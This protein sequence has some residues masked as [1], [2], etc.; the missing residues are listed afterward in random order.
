MKTLG[1]DV[2]KRN[3]NATLLNE[4]GE[5]IYGNFTFA[6][7]HKGLERLVGQLK[8]HGVISTDLRIGM[9]ATGH[10]WVLLYQAFWTVRSSTAFLAEPALRRYK[11]F[12]HFLDSHVFRDDFLEIMIRGR[13]HEKFKQTGTQGI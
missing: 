3:H 9:E 11:K 1:I 6:N 7:N 2:A 13:I 10:Y 12:L 4:D 8:S 5:V